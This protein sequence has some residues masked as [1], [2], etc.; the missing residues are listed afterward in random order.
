MANW[1]CVQTVAQSRSLW[2]APKHQP[3]FVLVALKALGLRALEITRSP[4]GEAL[5]VVGVDVHTHNI[6]AVRS[7]SLR[8]MAL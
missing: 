1:G 3:D 6:L 7:A 4:S 2:V 8:Q 5:R